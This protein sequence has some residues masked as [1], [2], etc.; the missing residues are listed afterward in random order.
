MRGIEMDHNE[1][2]QQNATER[3][4]LQELDPD[5]RD[6]FE[7]HLFDCQDCALDVRSGAMFVE[8]SKVILGEKPEAA[9]AR[10]PV[11][12]PAPSGWF[13]WMRPAFAAPALALLLI[14][15]GYQGV[16]NARLQRAAHSPQ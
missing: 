14:V 7:E 5:V 6:Q 13:G 16:T 15:I 10:V 3:Y 12:V 8:Q 2:V 4:L 11:R 1:A 9:V